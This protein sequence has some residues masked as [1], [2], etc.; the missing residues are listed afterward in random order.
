MALQP[1]NEVA[2]SCSLGAQP[3]SIGHGLIYSEATPLIGEGTHNSIETTSAAFHTL[4]SPEI[5]LVALFSALAR[6]YRQRTRNGGVTV[7]DLPEWP[8]SC[9]VGATNRFFHSFAIHK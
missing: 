3:V 7:N 2:L 5:C 9:A 6:L 8:A 1:L 4:M